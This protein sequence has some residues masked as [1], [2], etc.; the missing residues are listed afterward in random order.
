MINPY[1]TAYQHEDWIK[2]KSYDNIIG[3]LHKKRNTFV[4][5][6]LDDAAR[7]TWS[8]IHKVQTERDELAQKM[9]DDRKSLS[10]AMIQVFLLANL[11]YAKAVEFGELTRKIS[12]THDL[13]L[14]EDVKN[15]VKVSE[16]LALCIDK[17]GTGKQAEAFGEVIDKLEERYNKVLMPEVE[18]LMEE[19]KA[20]PV[21]DKLF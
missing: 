6:G 20:S 4:S 10:V 11:A 19:F 21:F 9:I 13:T 2:L 7:R 8:E 18:K 17:A 1:Y 12:G 14:Q 15:L 5:C 3:Q 16:E